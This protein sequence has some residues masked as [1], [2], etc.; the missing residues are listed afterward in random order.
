MASQMTD[1]TLEDHL[2][3][4]VQQPANNRPEPDYPYIHRELHRKGVTLQLLWEEYQRNPSNNRIASQLWLKILQ[5][6]EGGEDII[7][8]RKLLKQI[9]PALFEMYMNKKRHLAATHK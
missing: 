2:F 7:K 4:L 3:P 5:K 8:H 1:R 9:N 6:A